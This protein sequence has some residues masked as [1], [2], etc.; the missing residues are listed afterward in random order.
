M[1]V[2]ANAAL[3]DLVTDEDRCRRECADCGRQTSVTAGTVMHRTRLP[4]KTRFLTAHIVATHSSGIPALQLQA[5][6]GI[7]SDKSAWL[8]LQ[9]L[10]RAMVDPDRNVLQESVEVDEASMPFR[11]GRGAQGRSKKGRS[12]EGKTLLAGAVELSGDGKSRR[13]RLSGVEGRRVLP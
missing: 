4:L 11:E 13:I 12:A 1:V 7:G 6:L 3:P 5:Q 10:R 9:K 2:D 8:L